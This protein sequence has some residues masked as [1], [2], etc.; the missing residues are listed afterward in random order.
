[1]LKEEEF[2][3]DMSLVDVCANRRANTLPEVKK[4]SQRRDIAE[5]EGG[6][7]DVQNCPGEEKKEL[8]RGG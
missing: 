7:W 3:S 4:D 2:R 5:E 6:T 1:M 8:W